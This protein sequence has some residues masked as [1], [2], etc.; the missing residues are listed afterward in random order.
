MV[1]NRR[2]DLRFVFYSLDDIHEG[3]RQLERS[4]AVA[5]IEPG[6]SGILKIS[7]SRGARWTV[8]EE[9]ERGASHFG[10]GRPPHL[11]PLMFNISCVYRDRKNLLKSIKGIHKF[12]NMKVTV[13]E[14]DLYPGLSGDVPDFESSSPCGIWAVTKVWGAIPEESFFTNSPIWRDYDH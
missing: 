5:D 11:R 8:S 1:H 2:L 10:E 6:D 9:P 7:Q 12:V 3:I 4:L 14:L 13:E